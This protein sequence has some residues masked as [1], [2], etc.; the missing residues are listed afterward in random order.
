MILIGS[1]AAKYLHS[2]FR[3]PKDF[4]IV[5]TLEEFEKI[6]KRLEYVQ[7]ITKKRNKII[8][9]YGGGAVHLEFEMIS[10]ESSKFLLDHTTNQIGFF[11]N[12]DLFCPS[13]EILY[14]MKRSHVY[15]NI[16]W[17]KSMEDMHW[18][19]ARAKQPT[20]DDL[21]FYDL[22]FKETKKRFNEEFSY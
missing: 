10:S 11:L 17:K 22:R 3:K 13:T 2:D 9:T 4:D 19:K 6:I 16:H 20:Q 1:Q 15:W 7:K 18:L 8:V 14:L 5:G 21:Q 12:L